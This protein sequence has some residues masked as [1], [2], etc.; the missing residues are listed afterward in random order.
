MLIINNSSSTFSLKFFFF[1]P[2]FSSSF[3][4]FFLEGTWVTHRPFSS[5]C[6]CI[7]KENRECVA[8]RGWDQLHGDTAQRSWEQPPNLWWLMEK[9]YRGFSSLTWFR[10]LAQPNEEQIKIAKA[11]QLEFRENYANRVL[12]CANSCLPRKK[13]IKKRFS[14]GGGIF[15]SQSQ[16]EGKLARTR[17]WNTLAAIYT[18]IQKS[19]SVAHC[20]WT[21]ATCFPHLKLEPI[22]PRDQ[23]SSCRA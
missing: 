18:C 19:T 21:M 23:G 2:F 10:S 17:L 20:K 5:S 4:K 11:F 6:S 12:I 14:L 16:L 7:L 15:W 22:F 8:W 13:K 1:L 3:C 9:S